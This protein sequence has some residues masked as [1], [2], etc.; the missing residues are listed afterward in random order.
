MCLRASPEKYQP[1]Q[2][3]DCFVKSHKTKRTRQP[4]EYS[5]TRSHKTRPDNNSFGLAKCINKPFVGVIKMNNL[6]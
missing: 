4:F 3:I 2:P 1:N 6:F 5:Q